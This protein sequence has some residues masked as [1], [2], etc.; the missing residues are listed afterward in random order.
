MPLA[1]YGLMV[2]FSFQLFIPYALSILFGYLFTAGWF[3]KLRPSSA[4]LARLEAEGGLLHSVSRSSGWVLAGT[5]G[6]DTWIPVNAGAETARSSHPPADIEQPSGFGRMFGR[7]QNNYQP[8]STNDDSQHSAEMV[9]T[10][11]I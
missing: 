11:L 7:S 3:D 6:H 2:L 10:K 4:F 9:S 8:L 5:T 1:L